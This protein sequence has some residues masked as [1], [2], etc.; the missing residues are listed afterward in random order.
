METYDP[1]ELVRNAR[2]AAR[3]RFELQGRLDE[4]EAMWCFTCGFRSTLPGTPV[5]A[6]RQA[7]CGAEPAVIELCQICNAAAAGPPVR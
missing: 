6:W 2:I 1:A 3:Y 5:F 4:D 7:D